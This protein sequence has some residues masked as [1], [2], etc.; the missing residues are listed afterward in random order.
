MRPNNNRRK[1]HPTG[2][3]RV[4]VAHTRGPA[5]VLAGP[6]CLAAAY[7]RVETVLANARII[8]IARA[9]M[10]CKANGL[11]TEGVVSGGLG[12]AVGL[13][14]SWGVAS[15]RLRQ[16]FLEFIQNGGRTRNVVLVDHGSGVASRD[17]KD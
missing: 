2:A 5:K 16:A 7:T 9:P 8:C 12:S 17:V 6:T 3:P 4:A 1:K 11:S 10:E 13:G 14:P 15:G